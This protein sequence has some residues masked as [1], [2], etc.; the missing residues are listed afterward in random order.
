MIAGS[1]EA[2]QTSQRAQR[3]HVFASEPAPDVAKIVHGLHRLGPRSD[4]RSVERPG[5]RANDEIRNDSALIERAK[6]PD[7]DR[8]KAGTAG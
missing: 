1:Q 5:G 8:A 4:E 6:H 2:A 3:E 7:L